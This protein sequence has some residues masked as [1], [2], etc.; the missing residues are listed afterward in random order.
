MEPNYRSA[1]A[2]PVD[3]RSIG[4]APNSI[5]RFMSFP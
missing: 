2:G 3:A 1:G 4:E 5:V